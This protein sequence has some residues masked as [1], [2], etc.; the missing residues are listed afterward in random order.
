MMKFLK[1]FAIF[2]IVLVLLNGCAQ[3]KPETADQPEQTEKIQEEITEEKLPEEEPSEMTE[4]KPIFS[5]IELENAVPVSFDIDLDGEM[6]KV[7]FYET[8]TGEFPT[9]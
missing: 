6:E 3:T 4:E 9:A 7:A 8:E 5:F 1:K 2:F